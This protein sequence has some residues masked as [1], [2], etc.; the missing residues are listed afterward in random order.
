M[1]NKE[2][3]PNIAALRDKDI[4]MLYSFKKILF[5][6]DRSYEDMLVKIRAVSNPKSVYAISEIEA[7]H[8]LERFPV[9]RAG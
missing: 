3:Y 9:F 5:V 2:T 1:F 4:K 8:F 7:K 6:G